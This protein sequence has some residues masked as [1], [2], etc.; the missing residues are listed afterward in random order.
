MRF[1]FCRLRSLTLFRPA[2]GPFFRDLAAH[3]S[4]L[5]STA[6]TFKFGAGAQD[7]NV[8]IPFDAQYHQTSQDRTVCTEI[9]EDPT[10]WQHDSGNHSNSSGSH[11]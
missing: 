10:F 1:G 2:S 9:E 5:F 11:T 4:S 6:M 3:P 8:F 7:A